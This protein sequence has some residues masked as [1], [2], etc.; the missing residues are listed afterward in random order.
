MVFCLKNTKDA[1][2]NRF[3]IFKNVKLNITFVFRLSKQKIKGQ[4]KL[5]IANIQP[6]KMIEVTVINNKEISPDVHLISFARCFDFIP[7]QVIKISGGLKH[8]YRIYSI[9][10]GNTD[11]EV[12]VLFNIKKE[13]F[14]TP[15]LA[16]LNLGDRIFVSNP[17]GSFICDNYPAYWIA[18]GTGIAPF[19]SMF[20]SGIHEKKVLIHGSRYLNQFYF[21]DEFVQKMGK[22][23]TRCCSSE[24]GQN[25]FYGRV[26]DYLSET[27]VE[28]THRFFLCG[29]AIMVVETRDLLISKGIPFTNIFTEIYF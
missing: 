11:S 1:N 27:E 13:G 16:K 28:Q 14:L 21:E 24:K 9:C 29:S 6:D 15:L 20:R 8:P 26:T 19:Y 18:T 22:N 2:K 23:Y 25:L 17:Y 7:G 10:S 4:S 3:R 5:N 12:N